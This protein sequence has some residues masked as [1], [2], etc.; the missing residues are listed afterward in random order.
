M[1]MACVVSVS[2]ACFALEAA[3]DAVHADFLWQQGYTGSGTEIGVIDLFLADSS[4]PAISGNFL[5]SQKFVNGAAWLGGHATSVTGAALSQDPTRRGVAFDAGWWT[6]QTTNRGSITN[7]RTQ[8]VAAETFARGL[9]LLDGNP[10]EV[11][12]MSIGL[13]G[14][15]SAVDQWSL[16][17]D[18]LVATHGT[19]IVV[20]AGNDGPTS[21]FSGPPATAFNILSVGATGGNGATISEDYSQIAPYSSRGPTNGAR[22]K[23]DLVAPGSL[24]DLPTLGNGWSEASGTSFAAPLVAGGAALLVDMGQDRSLDVHPLV[25]KSVLLNSADKLPGWSH[26]ATEPLDFRYGAGQIN[27]QSAFFQYDAG[28]HGPG[29]VDSVGWDHGA[30]AG[31][32][33]NIYEFDVDLPAGAELTATLAWN[34]QVSSSTADVETTIYTAAPL[35]NLDL[36]LYELGDPAAPVASS[37][38][39]VDNV[40]HL[41]VSL[42]SPGHYALAVRSANGTLVSPSP[43]SLAW[44][45]AV[46]EILLPGDYNQN[47]VVDAADY[48]VW[49]DRLGQT[50]PLPNDDTAGVGPDDYTRW[51]NNFGQSLG[52]GSG[53]AS[54]LAPGDSPGAKYAVPEPSNLGLLLAM[55]ILCWSERYRPFPRTGRLSR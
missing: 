47:G 23:P 7:Q 48:T 40:E 17:L 6:A 24:L 44:N 41:L 35:E 33:D 54:D 27:L 43:Y 45:V 50:E 11:L 9:G 12:T 22:S 8:T 4:H 49:R 18:H 31:E 16:A 39:T 25:I 20:A 2:H 30:I 19:T 34:R 15:D 38:S 52:S 37:V 14:A 13:A 53:A 10:A 26:T 46:P 36:L 3:V 5:G 29:I 51:V 1:S 55:V 21:G 28:Q 32:A 42:A